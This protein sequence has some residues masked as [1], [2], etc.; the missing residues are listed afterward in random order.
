MKLFH[1]RRSA[2]GVEVTVDG[3]PLDAHL[4]LRDFHAGGFEWGYEGSGP[5]QLALAILAEHA[6]AQAA[7]Q[8][9]RSFVRQVIAELDGDEWC[10]S[11][12][13]IDQR[14][15]HTV[16]VPMDLDTL[17]RKVRGETE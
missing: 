8:G 2:S 1:G 15:S 11:G 17:L 4:N 7:L 16:E 5:S 3:V 10:L 14:L 12:D 6:G 9:Y 13:D